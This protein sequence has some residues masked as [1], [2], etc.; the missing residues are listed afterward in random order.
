MWR[1]S[2][3]T[4][5]RHTLLLLCPP[6][7]SQPS[8]PR[9]PRL[10]PHLAALPS[11]LAPRSPAEMNPP[12]QSRPVAS[13]GS[14]PAG[15]G[16][17]ASATARSDALQQPRAPASRGLHDTDPGWLKAGYVLGSIFVRGWGGCVSSSADSRSPPPPPPPPHSCRP[18]PSSSRRATCAR[19]ASTCSGACA[20][21]GGAC[22][23]AC[24]VRACF[25]RSLA[26]P[27]AV[28]TLCLCRPCMGPGP[29]P[30]A[31]VEAEEVCTFMGRT[32]ASA[33]GANVGACA[34]ARKGVER[35]CKILS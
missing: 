16:R 35:T 1:T 24:L 7:G 26:A 14:G 6:S 11:S 32:K 4:P 33:A 13:S 30:G 31:R 15:G 21:G 28:S 19:R 18:S 9:R 17:A 8:R 27:P 22:V 23:L 29:G 34:L 10:R 25:L 2:S 3:T 12:G 5:S 20:L